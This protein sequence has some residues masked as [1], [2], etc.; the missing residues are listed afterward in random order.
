[1][2]F[3]HAN[4]IFLNQLMKSLLIKKQIKMEQVQRDVTLG[5][6]RCHIGFNPSADD[7]IGTFKRMMADAIDYL[8]NESQATEDDEAKRVFDLAMADL[9]SAQMFGVKG[10]AKSLNF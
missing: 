7:K 10:I 1:M 3:T 4:L 5:E 8:N 2:I 9:E 6:K